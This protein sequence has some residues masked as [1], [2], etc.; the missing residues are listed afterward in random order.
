M[1]HCS[2][3]KDLLNNS[4]SLSSFPSDAIFLSMICAGIYGHID[5]AVLS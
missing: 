3:V 1:S 2:S 5:E 4:L